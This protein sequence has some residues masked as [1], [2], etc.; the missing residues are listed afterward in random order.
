MNNDG[1]LRPALIGGVLLGILSAVPILNLGNCL[2]CAWVIGGGM[3]AANL[4][5]KASPEAVKLGT[6]VTLG[7]LTGGI[8]GAVATLFGI[9]FQML[10]RGF[11]ARF[12]QEIQ[13]TIT[14][15]MTLS[16]EVRQMLTQMLASSGNLTVLAIFLTGF[17]NVIIYALIAMIGGVLGVALFEKRKI[18]THESLYQPPPPSAPPPGEPPELP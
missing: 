4:Y 6:G 9:P 2:C 17:L 8:G 1:L 12:D 7:V 3:L 10:L 5:I 16:P 14:E 13:R 11:V 18:E 15:Q